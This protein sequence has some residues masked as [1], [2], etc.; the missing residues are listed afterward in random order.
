MC[1]SSFAQICAYSLFFL[2]FVIFLAPSRCDPYLPLLQVRTWEAPLMR[3][4]T[5]HESS[6]T[7]MLHWA[8][9]DGIGLDSRQTCHWLGILLALVP[10]WCPAGAFRWA[11]RKFDSSG[12]PKQ[13]SLKWEQAVRLCHLPP[14]FPLLRSPSLSWLTGAPLCSSHQ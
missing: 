5:W 1:P 8:C 6:H 4:A 10:I 3:S 7:I 13:I 14:S 2:F 9:W 12:S 11:K